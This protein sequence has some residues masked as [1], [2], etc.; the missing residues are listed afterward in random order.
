MPTFLGIDE[1]RHI[2]SADVK[3]TIGDTTADLG[4]RYELDRTDD[5]T[6][7]SQ[8]PGQTTSAFITQQDLEK[9]DLFAVHGST[10]TLFDKKLTFSSGFSVT[11][12]DTDLSGSR[13][14]GPA[15]NALLSPHLRQITGPATS[16]SA[17]AAIRKIMSATL[18]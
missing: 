1:T 7:I 2:F 6:Y 14:Y 3:D 18:I 8:N 16:V 4:A 12:I 11:N 9:D 15:Y 10:V 17:G 5:S 13:I